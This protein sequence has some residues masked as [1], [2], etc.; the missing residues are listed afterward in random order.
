MA[1][2]TAPDPCVE[3]V[4][5]SIVV[6]GIQRHERILAFLECDLLTSLRTGR[7][8]RVAHTANATSVKFRG[9]CKPQDVESVE[10][11][12]RQRFCPDLNAGLLEAF[13]Q[14][15]ISETAE[16]ISLTA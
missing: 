10:A 3:R 14:A 4:D 2:N 9:R 13:E 16:P 8:A 12:L 5:Y 1:P 7:L 6:S 11:A 15:G